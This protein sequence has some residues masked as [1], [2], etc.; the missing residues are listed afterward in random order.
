MQLIMESQLTSTYIHTHI[1][2][3][4]TAHEGTHHERPSPNSSWIHNR[5]IHTYTHTHIHT[6]IQQRTKGRITKG[7]HQTHHGFT[8]GLSQ[9]LHVCMDHTH[10]TSQKRATSA[11]GDHFTA[12]RGSF[13]QCFSRLVG[14]LSACCVSA[15]VWCTFDACTKN[16]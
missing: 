4:T 8:N 13:D 3:H 14:A 11:N 9:R 5:P 1:H 7:H 10:K 6:H 2:T 16:G 12:Q 15:Q